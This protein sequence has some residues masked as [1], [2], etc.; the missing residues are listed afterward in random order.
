MRSSATVSHF[1]ATPHNLNFVSLHT[2]KGEALCNVWCMQQPRSSFLLRQFKRGLSLKKLTENS[3]EVNL[4]G[5]N[6]SLPMHT[7]KANPANSQHRQ[8][9]VPFCASF[10]VN[11]QL[12]CPLSRGAQALSFYTST[13]HPEG[14]HT[15]AGCRA[16]VWRPTRARQTVLH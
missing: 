6:N 12:M 13:E 11:V 15:T 3:G 16:A 5:C 8:K 7:Q 14:K 1:G 4:H 10:E 9:W 2:R